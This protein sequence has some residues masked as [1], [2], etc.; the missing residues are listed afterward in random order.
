MSRHTKVQTYASRTSQCKDQS[1]QIIVLFADP[2]RNSICFSTTLRCVY[3]FATAQ[4]TTERHLDSSLTKFT[5]SLNGMHLNILA[6][7]YQGEL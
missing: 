4:P 5:S 2:S 6:N 3:F 7:L 1:L